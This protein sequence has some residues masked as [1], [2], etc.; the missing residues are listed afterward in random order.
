MNRC[1]ARGLF[2]QIKGVAP[3]VPGK[4]TTQAGI[5]LTRREI[6]EARRIKKDARKRPF[7]FIL[8]CTKG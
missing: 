2:W 5:S 1:G 7:Y 8:F 4:Y 3:Q 6:P